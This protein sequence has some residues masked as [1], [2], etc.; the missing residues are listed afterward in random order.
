MA[1]K[2]IVT[3]GLVFNLFMV[4][5]SP[6]F[7]YSYH[8]LGLNNVFNTL[9]SKTHGIINLSN[10]FL[11][12]N[13]LDLAKKRVEGSNQA[14]RSILND[15]SESTKE[16]Y[17]QS[18]RVFDSVDLYA[19]VN[20]N[21]PVNTSIQNLAEDA[22]SDFVYLLTNFHEIIGKIQEI[23]PREY[24]LN[25]YES[26]I[27]LQRLFSVFQSYRPDVF[28]KKL[29][30]DYEAE[31]I[32]LM[33]ESLI[34][35]LSLANGDISADDYL[36]F[37]KQAARKMAMSETAFYLMV[38]LC[39]TVFPESPLILTSPVVGATSEIIFGARLGLPLMRLLSLVLGAV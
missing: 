8:Q 15:S 39:I 30:Q 28:G 5:I 3:I 34:K 27:V 10:E 36:Q 26:D 12:N 25:L 4:Q 16:I 14:L 1:L 35:T 13:F 23:D 38:T 21:L 32:P 6:A 9:E 31:I 18:I 7:G 17:K 2:V 33:G 20:S 29:K 22:P 24:D 37:I 19:L 11:S